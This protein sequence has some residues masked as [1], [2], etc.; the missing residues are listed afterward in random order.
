MFLASDGCPLAPVWLAFSVRQRR[1]RGFG[2]LIGAWLV[3][4]GSLCFGVPNVISEPSGGGRKGGIRGPSPVLISR[5][6]DVKPPPRLVR[7]M[8]CFTCL[9]DDDSQK[10]RREDRPQPWDPRPQDGKG[11]CPIDRSAADDAEVTAGIEVLQSN[12]RCVM[13]MRVVTVST[14]STGSADAGIFNVV[15]RPCVDDP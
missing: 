14:S 6:C 12:S 7:E 10:G 8:V 3:E 4:R 13:L 15:P 1:G 9:R 5:C 11:L 2:L